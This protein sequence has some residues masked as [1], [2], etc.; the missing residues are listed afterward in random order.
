M[1]VC[2]P[3]DPDPPP[4][5]ESDALENVTRDTQDL[6]SLTLAL[7]RLVLPFVSYNDERMEMMTPSDVHYTHTYTQQHAEI[8][9][10]RE[11]EERRRE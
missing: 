5:V 3:I 1:C 10:K 8:E 2:I 9:R 4:V 11:N 6:V 7:R